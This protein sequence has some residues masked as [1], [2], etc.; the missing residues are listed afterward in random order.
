[1][2]WL[3]LLSV[4]MFVA[5]AEARTLLV[6]PGGS[7]DSKTIPGAISM[8]QPGDEILLKPET[9]DGVVLDRR[10]SISGL[11]GAKIRSQRGSAIVVTAP[12]CEISNLS[13]EADG[14]STVVVLQ[15]QDNLIARCNILGG[16][17]GIGI[18]GGNNTLLDSD[19][20]S[21][22]GLEITGPRCKVLNSTLRG[23][24]GVR[25]KNT[26]E[27]EIQGC[28]LLTATGMEAVS[29]FGNRIENNS[30]SGIGFGVSLSG[31]N[32]NWIYGNNFSGQYM[33]GIDVLE[34][35]LNNISGNLIEGGKLGISLRGSENNSLDGNACRRSERAG[36]YTDG[37][38]NNEIKSNELSG[39]G[40]GILLANSRENLL[41]D[42]RASLNTYGIS[43]RGSLNNVLRNNSMQSNVYNLR[44]DSGEES[45]AEL[46]ESM[47]EFFV[48][49]I[50]PSNLVDG[51][52]ICYLVAGRDTEVPQGCGFIGLVGC[53]NV[54]VLNQTI[55]NSS[56][57]ILMVG[58]SSCR[59]EG[60]N[61]SRSESGVH[62][63]N[64]KLWAIINSDANGCENG[65]VA[66]ASQDGRF[67]NDSAENCSESGFRAD[68][69]LNLT[70]SAADAKSCN[71]GVSLM[72]SRL[73]SLLNCAA[74]QNSEA[75]IMLTGSHKCFLGKND[76]S[77]ND[78]GIALS[79]SN[80]CILTENRAV[81]NIQDGFFLEQLSSAELSENSARENGQGAF[82]HSSKRVKVEGN[83]LSENRKYGLRMSISSECNVTG[84]RFIGN[85]VSG[86]NLVDCT[87]NFLYHNVFVE[88]GFQNAVDNGENHWDAGPEIGGNFWSDH[89]VK[90]N[91]GN[92]PRE[93]PSKGV[94]R[95]PFESQ[96]GW[97]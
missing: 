34:S 87:G 17:T 41:A 33:S 6:D 32:G 72:N 49:D 82:V 25:L 55:S 78:R 84:N 13:I 77:M 81:A 21:G 35:S 80:A 27:N 67:E 64:S 48:Q 62:I 86:A 36:L 38:F 88:N 85:E 30:F 4:L 2:K 63:L 53:R 47:Q 79:G 45:S 22:L 50:D 3:I 7:G 66:L 5:C 10:L 76:V 68:G 91:P 58:S 15:S 20:Q 42:N 8:A 37:S 59:V 18:S 54:G 43:L 93:I 71:V 92:T 57:G 16:S 12:G 96:G 29:S 44:V 52:P 70:Y 65:F 73:C 97:R 39:N 75:G 19:V 60:C 26:S 56:A 89:R 9:Y 95:Y 28:R 11:S 14:S 46:A 24:V 69:A 74:D 94:D 51:R 40:N 23:D 83:N 31:S 61:I 1:M 90:G